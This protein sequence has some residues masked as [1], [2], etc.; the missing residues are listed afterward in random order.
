MT[1]K[2]EYAGFKAI[3]TLVQIKLIPSI[4]IN[5]NQTLCTNNQYS[6]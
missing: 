3:A 6:H 4:I 1:G 5:N 2:N